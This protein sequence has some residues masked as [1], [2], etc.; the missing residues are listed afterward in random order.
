MISQ[1]KGL[2]NRYAND[3]KVTFRQDF[4]V[5]NKLNKFGI[6]YDEKCCR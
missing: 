6:N 3:H 1:K 2:R 5:P 4:K